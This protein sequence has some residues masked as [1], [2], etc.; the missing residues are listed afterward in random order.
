MLTLP[1]PLH[2]LFVHLPI[3]LTLLVPAFA[4]GA[5]IA[6]RRGASAR[7]A[8]GITVA[9]LGLLTAS[10]FLALKTGEREEEFVEDVV[11]ES[12]IERHEEAAEAFLLASGVV[13]LLGA[14][15]LINGRTGS[16]ARGFA[17]AGTIALVGAG[18]QVGHSGGTLAYHEG[19][20]M[21]YTRKGG[22]EVTSANLTRG[23]SRSRDSRE[24]DKDRR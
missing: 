20:A 14:A 9:L 11:A 23:E 10:S 8:W 15:G 6:I 3:A 17:T 24:D 16:I 19:A 22:G 5:V 2:P 1:S 21:A 4:L 7:R 13:L 18:W 12:A